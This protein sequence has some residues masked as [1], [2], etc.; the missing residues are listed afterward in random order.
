[1]HSYLVQRKHYFK[2]L[3]TSVVKED[4]LDN[5]DGL[6][7]VVPRMDIATGA[8]QPIVG[9]DRESVVIYQMSTKEE[10]FTDIQSFRF[11]VG[12]WN[13]NGQS[14][15]GRHFQRTLKTKRGKI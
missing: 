2:L 13:V 12:T 9:R 4:P 8:A 6:A 14:P 7:D 1:M 5:M 11:F 15:D 3:D 10:Q